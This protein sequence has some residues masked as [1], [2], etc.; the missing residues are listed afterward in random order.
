MA[1]FIQRK[2]DQRLAIYSKFSL[3]LQTLPFTD[4][5]NDED[6]YDLDRDARSASYGNFK[7]T[8]PPFPGDEDDYD[9]YLTGEP[10]RTTWRTP[11]T[12]E[13]ETNYN[14]NSNEI[15]SENKDESQSWRKYVPWFKRQWGRTKDFLK[16]QYNAA[17]NHLG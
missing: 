10:E 1:F 14:N 15:G 2:N 13:K 6:D 11:T 16:D 4:D 5:S 8:Y 7:T 17:S 9:R 3:F 12:T